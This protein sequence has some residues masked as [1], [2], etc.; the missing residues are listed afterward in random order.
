[1]KALLLATLLG[2]ASCATERYAPAV[3]AKVDSVLVAAGIP[4]LAVRKL[5]LTGPVTIQLVQGNTNSMVGTDKTGQRA[6][7][8]STGAG[9]PVTVTTQKGGVPWWVFVG[10]GGLSIAAWQWLKPRWL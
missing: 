8:V 10:V 2:L 4:P 9:S 6:Q 1:M 7:A 3:D 5:K